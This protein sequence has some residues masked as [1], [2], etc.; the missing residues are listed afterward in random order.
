MRRMIW[1]QFVLYIFGSASFAQPS[2][3]YDR[4]AQ[5]RAYDK[6]H[7]AT[8]RAFSV[9]VS[10]SSSSVYKPPSSSSGSSTSSSYSKG[11]S[12]AGSIAPASPNNWAMTDRYEWQVSQ[13]VL[14]ER[15]NA[16]RQAAFI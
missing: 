12:T 6:L 1:M 15:A 16:A 7:A 8:T 13:G 2:S 5:N 10:S 11:S 3:Y 4:Q 14:K 9:P